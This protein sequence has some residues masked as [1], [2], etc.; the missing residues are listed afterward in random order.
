MSYKTEG[1]RELKIRSAESYNDVK[2]Y[3]T[4]AAAYVGMGDTN[5]FNDKYENS[6]FLIC[7]VSNFPARLCAWFYSSGGHCGNQKL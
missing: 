3:N 1:G 4:T 6:S 5:E 7:C 2:T